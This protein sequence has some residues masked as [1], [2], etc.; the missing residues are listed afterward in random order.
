MSLYVDTNIIIA[1]Y[2]PSDPLYNVVRTFFRRKE[3]FI[4]T[5]INLFELYSVIS[6]IRSYISLP[7]KIKSVKARVIVQYIVED[8]NLQT[9]ARTFL[10]KLSKMNV[11]IPAEYY[12]AIKL[13]DSLKLRSLDLLHIAYASLLGNEIDAFITGDIEILE[14]KDI[15]EEKTG[16]KV[17]EPS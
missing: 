5:P 13:A 3:S 4:I 9:L 15:I 10:V 12:L 16:V 1:Y 2:K 14:K 11:R 7:D 8:L 6:R 17:R